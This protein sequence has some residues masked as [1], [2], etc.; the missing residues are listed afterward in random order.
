MPR[1]HCREMWRFP[2]RLDGLPEN[3]RGLTRSI[4]TVSADYFACHGKNHRDNT[5]ARERHSGTIRAHPSC[6]FSVK[7]EFPVVDRD[8][9]ETILTR[10]FPGAARYQISSSVDALKGLDE[11]WK[12][13]AVHGFCSV[14]IYRTTF[15]NLIL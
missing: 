9:V 13:I 2:P 3:R 15:S 14:S 12:E 5:A 7:Q 11:E 4:S 10:R 1:E 8:K 6:P